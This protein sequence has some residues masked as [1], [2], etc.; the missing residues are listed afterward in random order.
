MGHFRLQVATAQTFD[1]GFV[2]WLWP[3]STPARNETG[4]LIMD[5]GSVQ[6][7]LAQNP[8]REKQIEAILTAMAH[9]LGGPCQCIFVYG[10]AST[11]K[12]RTVHSIMK[13]LN[14]RHAFVS[15]LETY[16]PRLLFGAVLSQLFGSTDACDNLCDFVRHLAEELPETLP[17]YIV[18]DQAERLRGQ[19]LL[20]A[21]ARLRELSGR[22]LCCILLSRVPWEK[23][24]E[25]GV[26]SPYRI[27]FPQY[28]ASELSQLLGG[29]TLLPT[30]LGGTTLS[31]RELQHAAA[32]IG[33]TP[34]GDS[35]A[36]WRKEVASRLRQRLQSVYLREKSGSQQ[37]VRI[38]LPFHARFLLLAAYL[39]SYNPPGTDRK[40]FVK[41][42]GT[43][44][45]R[46]K[47]S[48]HLSQHLLGPK[49]FPLNRLVAIFHAI[50]D[51]HVAPSAVTLAQVESLVSL[52]L[53]QRVSREEQLSTPRYKCLVD[54]DFIRAVART[55]AF[56]ILGHLN[57]FA[58]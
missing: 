35:C 7:V 46:Q 48:N 44:T 41:A 26:G 50:V 16:T 18:V 25:A 52:R 12:T 6:S 22:P 36:S 37:P 54:L 47:R 19:G 31:L 27:H 5:V 24:R 23:F 14:L 34:E 33:T 3:R 21:L 55:V 2:Y 13:T 8:C 40:F 45:K 38:E 4:E 49:Q 1:C 11:G 58:C 39:A 28:T 9:P 57:D 15:G 30:V 56:D 51:E 43:G 42:R 20:G 29:D 17:A 53:L 10:H 32:G